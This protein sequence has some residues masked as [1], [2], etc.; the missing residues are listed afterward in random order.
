MKSIGLCGYLR[1]GHILS[2]KAEQLY[3]YRKKKMRKKKQRF[4]G[5]LDM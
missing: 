1:Q 5:D 3:P 2:L 4:G